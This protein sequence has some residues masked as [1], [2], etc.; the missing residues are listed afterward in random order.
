GI[1]IGEG[2]CVFDVG[3][4][5]GLFSMYVQERSGGARVYAFEPGRATCAALR[6]NMEMYGLETK[7]YGIGISNKAGKRK[8]TYYPKMTA[9]SGL[10]ADEEEDRGVT[11][12][13]IK[14]QGV[15]LEEYTEELLEGR[16]ESESYECEL[17][18]VSEVMRENGE[19]ELELL[20]IDVE[21]SELDVLKGI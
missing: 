16:F 10:Y 4:N 20:K 19:E 17:R 15:E 11:R 6:A 3:A 2:G 7:V 9:S 8:F 12:A 13:F 21:K 14:Q 1:E 18:T 5:I